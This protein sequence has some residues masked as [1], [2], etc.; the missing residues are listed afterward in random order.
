[1][2]FEKTILTGNFHYPN[3]LSHFS[4]DG[5]SI[6]AAFSE[7]IRDGISICLAVLC[8][9]FPHELGDVA[10]LVASGLSLK[11]AFFYNLLSAITCYIGIFRFNSFLIGISLI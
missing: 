3:Y 9:E 8:E 10:I 4:S 6:G 5:I 11:Q 2:K 7:S 1:M